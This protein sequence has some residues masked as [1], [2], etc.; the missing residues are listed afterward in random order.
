MLYFIFTIDGDW[1]EYFNIELSDQERAPKKEVLEGLIRREIEVVHQMLD[2]RFVHFIHTSPMARDF[3]LEPTFLKLWGEIIKNDGDIGLHCHEDEPYKDYYYHYTSHMREVI[4]ERA[5]VFRKIGLDVK[6]YR[7]GFL[8][9]SR[10]TVSILEENGIYFDFSCEPGR[11]LS[12]RRRLISNWRGAPIS[13]YRMSYNDHRKAGDSKVW[14]IP[15]GTSKGKYLYFE[16]SSPEALKETAFDLKEKSRKNKC[17]M[18]VSV[19]SHSYEYAS[20]ER[21]ENIKQKIKLLKEYGSFIN[22]KELA[23]LTQPSP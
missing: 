4:S 19:L 22:L 5:S 3:F 21:I 6:C 9:F 23:S 1:L 20:L 10:D 13:H 18:I 14:E 2:G 12:H 16:K 8:G 7:G 15:I 11:F 17:D